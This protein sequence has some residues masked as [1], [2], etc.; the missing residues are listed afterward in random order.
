MGAD[1]LSDRLFSR[2]LGFLVW[3]GCLLPGFAADEG[4]FPSAEVRVGRIDVRDDFIQ[5]LVNP[6]SQASGLK[7]EIDPRLEERRIFL[8]LQN[9]TLRSVLDVALPSQ[10]ATWEL[11]DKSVIL[12]ILPLPSPWPGPKSAAISDIQSSTTRK[13]FQ[14]GSMSLQQFT[15][16]LSEYYKVN[17]AQDFRMEVVPIFVSMTQVTLDEAMEQICVPRRLRWRYT[18]E[19][20]VILPAEPKSLLNFPSPAWQNWSYNQL[21]QGEIA[22]DLASDFGVPILMTKRAAESEFTGILSGLTLNDVL[23]S[24]CRRSSMIYGVIGET[25]YLA[26]RDEVSRLTQKAEFPEIKATLEILDLPRN[27]WNQQQMSELILLSKRIPVA[28]LNEKINSIKSQEGV[29]QVL[30]SEVSLS[31]ESQKDTPVEIALKDFS[32]TAILTLKFVFLSDDYASFA[33]QLQEQGATPNYPLFNLKDDLIRFDRPLLRLSQ[34]P[35]RA[36]PDYTRLLCVHFELKDQTSLESTTPYRFVTWQ[37]PR[38][39]N[40]RTDLTQ[41]GY[42]RGFPGPWGDLFLP[43][44]FRP[45]EERP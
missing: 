31:N 12:R 21:S 10:G 30:E 27:Q 22:Q 37:I 36:L 23:D 4:R 43:E 20:V 34:S 28:E 15:T 5:K 29:I 26:Q 17:F 25:L 19:L 35:M 45:W 9:I 44:P 13:N 8:S 33:V 40:H 3:V 42:Y 6:L 11:E 39:F 16:L 14:V 41:T 7:V 18:D 38:G 1:L 2:L 32:G 24:F